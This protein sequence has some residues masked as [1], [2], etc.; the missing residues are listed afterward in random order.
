[1]IFLG[2]RENPIW[3]VGKAAYRDLSRQRVAPLDSHVGSLFP[4][5]RPFETTKRGVF[6][7]THPKTNMEPEND[8]F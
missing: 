3:M 5:K 2:I 7:I 6:F 4:P 8:G 1:M